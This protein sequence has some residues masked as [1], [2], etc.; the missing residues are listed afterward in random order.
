M[1]VCTGAAIYGAGF[2]GPTC[3]QIKSFWKDFDG[4]D[5]LIGA[6]KNSILLLLLLCAAEL[7]FR[8]RA[9]SRSKRISLY[10][11]TTRLFSFISARTGGYDGERAALARFIVA[12]WA[13]ILLLYF[14]P[15]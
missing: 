14:F 1:S 7:D 11:A 10:T 6:D 4:A 15:L 13:R 12:R 9:Q 3:R 2:I 5:C 8:Q